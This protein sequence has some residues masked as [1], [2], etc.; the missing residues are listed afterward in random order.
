MASPTKKTKSTRTAKPTA[1]KVA[2]KTKAVAKK[3]TA[4]PSAKVAAKRPTKKAAPRTKAAKKNSSG[5]M[6]SVKDGVQTG[7]HAVTDLVIKVTPDALL[8]R[9][10]KAKKK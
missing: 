3:V 5:L 7:L 10:A 4:K 1:S 2:A 9:S 6:Q 8:P